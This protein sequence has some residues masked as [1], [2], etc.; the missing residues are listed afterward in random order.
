MAFRHL[1]RPAAMASLVVAASPA[2]A[3][4]ADTIAG[5]IV[6]T[7]SR[8]GDPV[9]LSQLGASVSVIDAD[10]MAQR[11]TRFVSDIL[12]D[13]PGIAVNRGI[14][15]LTQLR[16]RGA[17]GNHV[18]VLIDGIEVSDPYQ[19]E[20]DF[21]SLIA[22]DAARI[23]VLRG[24]QSS[25]YGSDAIGGVIHY[26]TASGAETP[27]VQ[28]RAEG[29]SFGSYAGRARIAG[30]SGDLDY[31]LSSS[32][33]HTDGTPT[34]R[35]GNRDIGLDNVGATAKL[36]WSPGETFRLSA[37]GRYNLT[38]ADS[39]NSELDTGSP[40]FGYLVDSPGVTFRN[41]AYYALLRGELSLLD[42]RWTTALSGQ[43]ADTTRKG[44]NA[45]GLDFGNKGRRLKG[46]LESTIRFGSG[47]VR[48]RVTG[49]LDIE[50]EEYRTLTASPSPFVFDGER[51]SD[52][53]GIVGQYDLTVDDALAIGASVRRDE[54]NRFA[55]T[56]TWRAQGSY[57]FETG[58]RLHAAYG[59]G[60]KNPGYFDLYGYSD[61]RY[62]GNPGLKP[63]RSKGWEAGV[64]QG[65]GDL[66]TIGVTW[67]DN[68][69]TDEVFIT[70]P[71]PD[72]TATPSNR[73]NRSKQHGIEVALSARP[74]P[75]LRID[76]AYT[77]LHARENGAVEQRRPT[78]SGSLNVTGFSRD[79]RFSATFTARYNGRQVDAAYTDPS[80]VPVLV[81]LQEYVLINL[82]A[83]YRITPAVSLFGR[84]EN[85]LDEEYEEVFSSATPGRGAF[86]GVSVRF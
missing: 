29:G 13:V 38:D 19:G 61:G 27:G 60:V 25:L 8:S 49:A 73:D 64:E 40:L 50:R 55:D 39:N 37:V 1:L 24:Q 26:I 63:E 5:T 35:G 32:W 85:L 34:A 3:E 11:Q 2:L 51:H 78:H 9:A 31:A 65:W 74:I 30:V 46:S 28:L 15:G 79:E 4:D 6:V 16:L 59:T 21:G 82:S 77:W 71:A 62:I 75:Q 12:R 69:L 48:H 56:T 17:E 43:I 52:N 67:F 33:V 86:G 10:T 7:A 18:L 42:G 53:L 84:V 66:A 14:G 57:R 47:S 41:E 20:F 44:F 23:E 68:Q 45:D 58:T 81:S 22:D 72:Y 54:N 83:E 36:A 70:Y 76:A 80:Y